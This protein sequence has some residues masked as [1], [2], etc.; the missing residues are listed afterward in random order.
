MEL[1]FTER[2]LDIDKITKIK[3]T[4]ECGAELNNLYNA[5]SDKLNFITYL[6]YHALT[7]MKAKLNT[8]NRQ[9]EQ[10]GNSILLSYF[11]EKLQGRIKFIENWIE[12]KKL[13]TN[14][15]EIPL[16]D[17]QKTSADNNFNPNQFNQKTN[18]LFLYLID[19]YDKNGK[20]KFINIFEFM[21]KDIDKS[22]YVFRFTQETYKNHIFKNYNTE[23]KK[24]A[25]AEYIYKESEKPLLNS[26]VDLF[27]KQYLK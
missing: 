2:N 18:D 1:G 25:I 5:Q 22:K 26:F 6:E 11:A 12:Q 3:D 27:E 10:N 15:I 7:K 19:N 17:L 8:D 4:T 14:E 23:I 9:L 13:V 16:I 24:F 20:I 21:K